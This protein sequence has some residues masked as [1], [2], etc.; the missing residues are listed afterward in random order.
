MSLVNIRPAITLDI[1][2]H[3]LTPSTIKAIAFDSGTRF[4][5]AMIRNHGTT[6]AKI[7]YRI[8]ILYQKVR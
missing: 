7:H 3:N 1:Y 5:A 6:A 2:D 8:E 4:V